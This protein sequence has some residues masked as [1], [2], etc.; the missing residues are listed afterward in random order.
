MTVATMSVSPSSG[1][2]LT[3]ASLGPGTTI[4]FESAGQNLALDV[5]AIDSQQ[6]ILSF[7]VKRR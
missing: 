3:K 2:Q 1:P 4:P 7:R 5:L 6:Q